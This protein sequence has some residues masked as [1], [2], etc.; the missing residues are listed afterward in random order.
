MEAIPSIRQSIIDF[1]EVVDAH[2]LEHEV[3]VKRLVEALDHLAAT[4]HGA[5]YKFDATD[6]PEGPGCDFQALYARVGAHFPEFGYY[7]LA[8]PTT[9]KIGDAQI[10]VGDAVDDVADIYRDLSRVLWRWDNTSTDDALWH[11]TNSYKS[12][13][14]LHLRSLQYYVHVLESGVDATS[15]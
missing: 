12:H 9:Q 13:W 4:V 5:T 1:I 6:Y 3:R 10:I 14:G 2:G 11:F 7:N 15:S 8:D